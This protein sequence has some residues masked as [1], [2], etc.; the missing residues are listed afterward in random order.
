M[1]MSE[2]VFVWLNIRDDPYGYDIKKSIRAHDYLAKEPDFNIVLD[3]EIERKDPDVLR[4]IQGVWSCGR[5]PDLRDRIKELPNV[6]VNS[7]LGFCL[8]CRVYFIV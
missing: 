4:K 6:K 2:K 1:N 8:C 7:R 5:F 3:E